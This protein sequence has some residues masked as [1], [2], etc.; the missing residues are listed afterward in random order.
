[1]KNFPDESVMPRSDTGEEPIRGGSIGF[2]RILGKFVEWSSKDKSPRYTA[3][4]ISGFTIFRNIWT[5]EP[6][7]VSSRFDEMFIKDVNL[8]LEYYDTYLSFILGT[9]L[10]NKKAPVIVYF[11]DYRHVAKDI[12]REMTGRRLDLFVEYEKFRRRH[13]AEEGLA[14]ETEFVKCFWASVGG[15][16]YPHVDLSRK[17]RE[18]SSQPN[19]LYS[20]GSPVCLISAIPLD[21]HI[22]NRIRSLSLLESYTAESYTPFDFRFKLDKEGRI[23]FYPVTHL[24]FGDNVLINP[25]LKNKLRR[26]VLEQAIKEKWISRGEE[27]LRNKLAKALNIPTSQLRRYDFS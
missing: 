15:S 5:M 26:D 11:P 20:S 25:M 1:M 24:V 19:S 22:S 14:K 6:K 3:V 9:L 13:S 17:F 16:T 7:A 23:P 27:E 12:R 18:I 4:L 8:F 21:L 10:R 2:N